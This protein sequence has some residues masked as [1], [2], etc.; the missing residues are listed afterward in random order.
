MPPPA[1]ANTISVRRRVGWVGG[2][3]IS[4]LWGLNLFG[5]QAAAR[6]VWRRRGAVSPDL[7]GWCSVVGEADLGVYS[8]ARWNWSGGFWSNF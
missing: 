3:G 5:R 4:R 1:P 8:S 2:G 7:G 6:R